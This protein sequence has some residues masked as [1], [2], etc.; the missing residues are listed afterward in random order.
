MRD[1]L[2][3]AAAGVCSTLAFAWLALAMDVHWQQVR[4]SASP[5]PSVKRLLRVLAVAT[6]AISLALCLTVDHATMAT[7]VWV[8]LLAAGALLVT[9]TLSW[10]P[11]W[12]APAIVWLPRTILQTP[13]KSIA[14]S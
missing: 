7:L 6:L 3:L 13:G 4:A 10:Q 11:R 14:G 12:L 2:L 8:M 5:G 1:S 9:F